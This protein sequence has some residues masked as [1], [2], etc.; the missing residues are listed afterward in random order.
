MR[1]SFIAE[2]LTD[3][4][5]AVTGHLDG[6][7]VAYEEA[8]RTGKH[9]YELRAVWIDEAT[10]SNLAPPGC[11]SAHLMRA[12]AQALRGCPE[13][14]AML[15]GDLFA[16]EVRRRDQGPQESDRVFEEGR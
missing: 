2:W 5:V 1:L 15:G 4:A 9:G 8:W 12:V 11:L 13:A 14:V 16:V 10:G 6:R 3:D 7:R